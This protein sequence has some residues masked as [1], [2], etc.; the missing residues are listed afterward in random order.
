VLAAVG[1]AAGT[2]CAIEI[3]LAFAVTRVTDALGASRLVAMSRRPVL[4]AASN[5]LKQI[6]TEFCNLPQPFLGAII[7]AV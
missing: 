3:L 5:L 4:P 2:V 6:G 1:I 7:G